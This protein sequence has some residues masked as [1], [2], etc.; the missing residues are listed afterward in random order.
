[1]LS[2]IFSFFALN[3][4]WLFFIL[5][6][7]LTWFWSCS[8]SCIRIRFL[9][10]VSSLRYTIFIIWIAIMPDVIKMRVIL[11]IFIVVIFSFI[12]QTL[13][14]F[15]PNLLFPNFFG[16]LRNTWGILGM[17]VHLNILVDISKYLSS[18]FLRILF[19]IFLMRLSF[20]VILLFTFFALHRE[21]QECNYVDIN[22]Q[23]SQ[24]RQL[25][26]TQLQILRDK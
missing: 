9:I 11:S 21:V 25:K 17:V 14:Y 13:L 5:Y 16:S 20:D 7:L 1:M 6:F 18:F 15:L 8:W 22:V 26:V 2:F 19:F 23:Y 24:L 12:M 10:L 4:S 3:F